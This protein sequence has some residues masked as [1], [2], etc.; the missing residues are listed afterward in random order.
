[1]QPDVARRRARSARPKG[2]RGLRAVPP[3]LL[4]LIALNVLVEFVL[5]LSDFGVIEPR[6]R[7]LAYQYGGFWTGLL[8]NW[9]PNYAVQPYAMF[10][11]YS[12]LHAGIAHLLVN[13]LTLYSFGVLIVS[14]IGQW[15]FLALYAASAL[16]GAAGFGILSS[17][18]I[19]MVG[20]SGALFG[21][22]GAW[23]AW[24]YVDRY[25][26]S[27]ELWPVFRAALV[28]VVL[29][30]VLYWA[31]SGRLAWETHLGGFVVGWIFAFLIDPTSRPPPD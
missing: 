12:F 1:M 20:A 25:T 2:V 15:R 30:V 23:M 3:A 29:N 5:L 9:Q 24:N 18:P 11:T 13:M 21:L 14:R 28:L 8:D 27:V 26:A 22:A 10:A 19:P 6:L 16:G 4:A 17:A 31:M 7:G